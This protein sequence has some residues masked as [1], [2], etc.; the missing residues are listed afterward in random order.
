M[1][2]TSMSTPMSCGVAMLM[3][4]KYKALFSKAMPEPLFYEMVK[5]NTKDLGIEGVDKIYGAGFFT[6]QPLELNIWLI[7]GSKTMVVNGANKEMD[8]PAEIENGRFDIPFRYIGQETGAKIKW[9]AEHS[10]GNL[11]Y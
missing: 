8:V 2:G 9:D 11:R 1:S 4:S 3:G 6:L 7:N 10:S 5:F